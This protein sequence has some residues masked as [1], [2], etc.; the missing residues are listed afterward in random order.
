M[1]HFDIIIIGGGP[2]GIACGIEAKKNG[3]SYL[4]IEKGC[5][6][7]SLYHYPVNMQ[8]FSSSELL[9]LDKI[10]FI[11]KENKPRR[12]EALEYYRRVVTTNELNINLFETVIE[13]Q[14]DK[15]GIFHVK[16]SK[17]SYTAK[18][19]IIATGFY[20]IPNP[21]NIPGE[22]LPKVSHY[23]TDPHYY[24]GMDVVV[25]GASNSSVD[26]ALE[27]YRKGAKVTMVV[28]DSEISSHVKY[29]VKPDIENRIKEGSITAL[30]NSNIKEITDNSVVINN[31][32]EEITIKNDFVLALTGYRPNFVFLEQLGVSISNDENRTP[33]YNT[34]TMET[35]VT[36]LY[37]AGVV[38]GGLNTH[39]WFIENSR[40]HAVTI[41]THII[42]KYR[43]CR[44]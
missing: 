34:E 36:N 43:Y 41:L 3:L 12:S 9:E 30:F 26:A 17:D 8:F 40:I 18:D 4:I 21:L 1:K 37:L 2:I 14:K 29:W 42:S 13:A 20:D 16:T 25:V 6:V 28:R 44:F 11:S 22:N 15:E 19:V 27:C 7:N 5:L 23:Y 10:P 32:N 35:N 31:N 24:A 39:T 38:C 33:T